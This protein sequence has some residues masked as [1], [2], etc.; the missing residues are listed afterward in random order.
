MTAL[1]LMFQREYPPEHLPDFTRRVEALRLDELWVVEDCFYAGGIAQAAAALCHSSTLRVGIGILPAVARNPAFTALE[2]ASLARLAPG[3]LLAGI[4]HG[5]TE[6]M[7]QIGALPPSQLAALEE[8][9]LAV[10]AILRGENYSVQGKWAHLRDVQ[11]V[12][13]P[14]VAP[15]VLLG[16]RGAKSLELSGRAADGTI[17]AEGASPSYV[18]RARERIAAGRA[19]AGRGEAHAVTVYMHWAMGDDAEPRVRERLALNMASGK[20]AYQEALGIVED[21]R[22][23]LAQGGVPWLRDAMPRAWL[24]AMAVWGTPEDCARALDAL[25]AAG[26]DSVVL[27]PLMDP[28]AALDT[29]LPRLL[30]HLGR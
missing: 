25:R 14:S 29:H 18:R 17:L 9:A 27:V 10:R 28:Q 23:L 2:L 20:D 15:P 12:H 19:A 16:V 30:A 1:G 13:P 26:A 6:W 21:V 7:A 4:G 11:L 22:A 5:V 3:R 24:D 8:A